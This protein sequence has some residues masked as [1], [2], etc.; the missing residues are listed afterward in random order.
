M[1]DSMKSWT[2]K[3]V[4]VTG[5][6]GGL[7][8]AIA[9]RYAL[10][11]AT[12]ALADLNLKQA[13]AVAAD[14]GQGSFG[15]ACDVSKVSDCEQMV[16]T[17]IDRTGRLDLLING[18]GIWVEGD[19]DEMTEAQWDR[20]IDVNLKGTFFACRYA[21]PALEK[22]GG[23]IIN[24]SSDAGLVGNK[25]AAI[26]CASKG[27]VSL[28]TKALA[29][30]LAPRG[31]R[32]NAVCPCDIETPMIEFQANTYGNGDPEAYKRSL[33]S[34]YPQGDRARFSRP[35]EIAAF[36]YAITSPEMSPIVGACLPIDFGL[37]AGY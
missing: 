9:A 29:L 4:L 3:T 35:E 18:A 32:V 34:K 16:A 7:G 22:T 1:T 14:I 2:G 6:G 21:I 5:G 10:A 31:V 24:V 33:L 19:A 8:R 15:I 27:G 11:G 20:V 23:Q 17:A 13:D 12:I 37:T 26:Y 36:I 25:G 30:E 28:L